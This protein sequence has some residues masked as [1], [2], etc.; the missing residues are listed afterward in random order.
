MYCNFYLIIIWELYSEVTWQYIFA[1]ALLNSEHLECD[2]NTWQH[3]YILQNITDYCLFS[4]PGWLYMIS[5]HILSNI[6]TIKWLGNS[7]SQAAQWA[8]YHRCRS[9]RLPTDLSWEVRSGNRAWLR[10]IPNEMKLYSWEN[11]LQ[12]GKLS[13]AMFNYQR[14]VH[15]K[16]APIGTSCHSETCH[17]FWHKLYVGC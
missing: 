9:Q 14:V 4:K 11:Q 17:F 7:W 16:H 13:I 2:D 5:C 3:I 15:F 12:M 8:R 1:K 10:K 6:S